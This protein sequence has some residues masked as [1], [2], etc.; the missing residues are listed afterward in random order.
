MFCNRRPNSA[1][2]MSGLD[3]DGFI[4][5][6]QHSGKICT[7]NNRVTCTFEIHVAITRSL[8][9]I[10]ASTSIWLGFCLAHVPARATCVTARPLTHCEVGVFNTHTHP[11]ISVLSQIVETDW[12]RRRGTRIFQIKQTVTSPNVR[13]LP[14]E[15]AFYTCA[16]HETLMCLECKPDVMSS[17]YSPH[18]RQG[19][20]FYCLATLFLHILHISGLPPHPCPT[21]CM[22]MSCSH[23][24]SSSPSF[25]SILY[26][27]LAAPAPT[28]TPTAQPKHPA[29]RPGLAKSLSRNLPHHFLDWTV[30]G[31]KW[32]GL[33]V[34]ASAI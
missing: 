19:H 20:R 13:L 29:H 2:R 3:K 31:G 5:L 28:P 34:T 18:P 6:Q 1:G 30:P 12:L 23:P 15:A 10:L 32:H 4:Q 24:S 21:T 17:V 33:G 22:Q 7:L 25:A 14:R 9:W 26:S 8:P 16:L 11:E 27:P